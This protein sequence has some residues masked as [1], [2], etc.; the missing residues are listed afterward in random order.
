[1]IGM[2]MVQRQRLQQRIEQMLKL[3]LKQELRQ[4]LKQVL[5]LLKKQVITFET[6][7][8]LRQKLRDVPSQNYNEFSHEIIRLAGLDNAYNMYLHM[9]MAYTLSPP[10]FATFGSF[11]Q[12]FDRKIKDEKNRRNKRHKKVMIHTLRLVMEPPFKGNG[13]SFDDLLEIL[14]AVP[15]VNEDGHLQWALAGGWAVELLTGVMRDHHDI[16]TVALTSKPVH[17]DTDHQ[18]SSNYFDIISCSGHFLRKNCIEEVEIGNQDEGETEKVYVLCP[19]FL[20]LSKFLRPPRQHDWLDIIAL[21]DHY[22]QDLNLK[23][24]LK[25]IH[26]NICSFNRTR[27]LMQILRL[28]DTQEMVARL[29]LFWK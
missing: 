4:L 21:I 1:M 15:Q 14:E 16:D 26:K 18:E 22:G 10:E 7:F 19:E 3:E 28:D 8:E 17:L 5:K 9:R 2:G 24:I 29:G 12:V 25:I 20:F 6:L 23:L 27:E 11:L 13:S